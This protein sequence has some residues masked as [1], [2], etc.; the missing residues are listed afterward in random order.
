MAEGKTGRPRVRRPRRGDGP[1][2]RSLALTFQ[3]I[4]EEMVGCTAVQL[5]ERFR[6]KAMFDDSKFH[7]PRLKGKGNGKRIYAYENAETDPSFATQHRYGI[8]SGSRTGIIHVISLFYAF[9]RCAAA[10]E[11]IRQDELQDAQEFARKLK[12]LA[13][14]A[15][16]MIADAEASGLLKEIEMEAWEDPDARLVHERAVIGRLF[17][18]YRNG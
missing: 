8:V 6:S 4:R 7:E 1:I 17:N 12:A 14:A 2:P 5:D 18:A 9:L 11:K 3:Y 10:D 15:E 13:V 16:D